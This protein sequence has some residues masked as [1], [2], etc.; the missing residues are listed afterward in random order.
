M[1]IL[2]C[3][4][5]QYRI[6]RTL[7]KIAPF[8]IKGGLK[9]FAQSCQPGLLSCL[10]ISN[11]FS[12]LKNV[13]E[14]LRLQTLPKESF[15]VVIVF[16]AQGSDI[17]YLI[18][19][20]KEC[21]NII[22]HQTPISIRLLSNLRNISVSLSRGEY[23]LFLDDDTRIFQKDFLELGLS[24]L[25]QNKCQVLIPQAHSLY[26]IVGK[27]YDFLDKYSF[28]TRCSLYH[29]KAIEDVGGFLKD[30]QTH[31]DIEL[32]I[33]LMIKE[34][35]VIRAEELNYYH[36]PLYFD[37]MNKPLAI[38]QTIFQTQK[39]YSLPF[40]L[41]VYFNAMRFLPY[42]LIPGERYRHWFKI[43][44]G[45]LLYPFTGKSYYY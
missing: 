3:N 27:H 16:D 19:E 20:Y 15:E 32:S 11:K 5:I 17:L 9:E 8:N 37:S 23:F 13:L 30:L 41:L 7:Y 25:K 38:G 31:E 33:R 12:L 44:L 29:R 21:L 4:K 35:K 28:T 10:I 42:G 34:L 18:D 14:D 26:G 24:I 2:N 39:Y 36:P 1:K 22:L 6:L 40:W 43:S 45:V